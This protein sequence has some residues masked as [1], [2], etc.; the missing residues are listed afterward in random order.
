MVAQPKYSRSF[1]IVDNL[2]S[3]NRPLQMSLSCD[4]GICKSAATS[5]CVLPES[6]I[7]RATRFPEGPTVPAR[8]RDRRS[9]SSTP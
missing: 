1:R 8:N 9:L 7:A 5:P 4:C 3:G 2:G 6:S